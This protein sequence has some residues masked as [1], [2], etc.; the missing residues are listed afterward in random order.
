MPS[1]EWLKE[2]IYKRA[3]TYF[4]NGILEETRKLL[5]KYSEN[6]LKKT[7]GIAYIASVKLLKNEI[8]QEKALEM[9]K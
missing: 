2:H 1:A 4:V 6:T 9:I 7:H 3:G 5:N 8:D